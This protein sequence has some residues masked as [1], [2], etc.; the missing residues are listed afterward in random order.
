[1]NELKQQPLVTF[2]SE[3]TEQAEQVEQPEQPAKKPERKTCLS[4]FVSAL[5]RY[6]GTPRTQQSLI[7]GLP[8]VSGCIDISQLPVVTHRA[9]LTC[10]E[11]N[12]PIQQLTDLDLPAL[13][14]LKDNQACVLLAKDGHQLS[15]LTAAGGQCKLD[16]EQ[17]QADYQGQA[18]SI[19]PSID[20]EVQKHYKAGG[21]HWLW[22]LAFQH[23]RVYFEA[24]IGSV[25]V[26]LLALALPLFTMGVYDRIIPNFAL[27]SLYVLSIGMVIVALIDFTL[28]NLRA[29]MLDHVGQNI[30]TYLG[31]V[32]FNHLLYARVQQMQTSGSTANAIREVDVL[33]EF[34]NSTTLSLI[35]DVPF[36]VL[37][38]WVIYLIGGE[39]AWVPVI[40]VPLVL[41]VF[42]VTQWPLHKIMEKAYS[43]ASHRNSV[44]FEVLNGMET[45]K[46][47]GAESWAAAQWEKAHAAGVKTAFA[48]RFYS[49][50]NQHMLMAFQLLATVALI[51]LGVF[52]IQEGKLSFGALF[53]VIILNG[54]AMAPVS[55]IAQV[56]GR[57]HSAWVSYQAVSRLMEMPLEKNDEHGNVSCPVIEGQITFDQ[58]QF[59]Y[60][61]PG[62]LFETKIE[63]LKNI[64]FNV[65]PGEKIAILG[66]IGS[67]KSTVLKLLLNL[68]GPESGTVRVDGIDSR[69]IDPADLRSHIGYVPQNLHFFRGTIKSNLLIHA[70]NAPDL[71]LLQAAEVAGI[72]QWLSA[73]PLGLA[74]PV[75][76]RGDTLS[77]GQKQS[78]ALARALVHNPP[79]L[80][81][82]EPTSLLD[83][84]SEMAF[85]QRLKNIIANK[86]LIVATHRPAILSLVDRILVINQG[87]IVMDGPR[88]AV[89]DKLG[90]RQ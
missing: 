26:N 35:A 13:L 1:M 25:I 69:E 73:C 37:F 82:D 81:M 22:S 80:L 45:I 46:S 15:V 7:S 9:G 54:R 87:V 23:K 70:P 68:I 11:V 14:L 20:H 38:I 27:E 65:R 89:L 29:Y 6:F 84:Q 53:A 58:V 51:V 36:L 32:V 12:L 60:A 28:R 78:L 30:D 50:L 59:S 72:S 83:S 49:L 33:R 2:N 71:L 76:E 10:R 66:T 79:I 18:F 67:G 63:V 57:L 48:S 40:F 44:L 5:T 41:L 52:M 56:I 19:Q 31:N 16:N 47:L 77:G 24:A 39:L 21:G 17:L 8:L 85:L 88:Q 42:L 43:N 61:V 86:T 3:Q 55:Q 64:S 62:T 90:A 34:L 74:Q 75:G 4:E